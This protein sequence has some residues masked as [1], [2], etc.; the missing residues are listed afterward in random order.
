MVMPADVKV[1]VLE[2]AKALPWHRRRRWRRGMGVVLLAG[3][4]L[5]G[6]QWRKPSWPWAHKM[7]YYQWQCL[8]YSQPASQIVAREGDQAVINALAA[9]DP[10]YVVGFD[11]WQG[12]VVASKSMCRSI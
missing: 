1:S 3:L 9:T 5:A 6:W 4:A 12:F 8:H 11:N 2:Y 10:D 7:Q